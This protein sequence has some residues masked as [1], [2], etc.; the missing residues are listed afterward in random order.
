MRSRFCALL[1]VVLAVTLLVAAPALA[2]VEIVGKVVNTD[3][4]K[5]TVTDGSSEHILDV[6]KETKVTIKG[7]EAKLT[8][9]KADQDVKVTV[10]PDGEKLVATNIVAE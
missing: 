1:L 2:A 3:N 5:L 7:K 6:T 8:D 9:L 4:G 10:E